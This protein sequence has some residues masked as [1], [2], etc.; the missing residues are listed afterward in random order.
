MRPMMPNLQLESPV[1]M[2]LNFHGDI[3]ASAVE[4]LRREITA[5]HDAGRTPHHDEVV[6][7]L[8]SP[9]GM[10]H[11]YGLAASQLVANPA[12][13]TPPHGMCAST[14]SPPAAGT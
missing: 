10:V 11:G 13:Q 14:R 12:G 3:R 5:S 4:A 9:G 1:S 8:E 7:N 2:Y 6:I